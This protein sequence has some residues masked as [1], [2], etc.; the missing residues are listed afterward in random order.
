MAWPCHT[1]LALGLLTLTLTFDLGVTF[2]PDPWKVLQVYRVTIGGFSWKK[3]SHYRVCRWTYSIDLDLWPWFWPQWWPLTPTLGRATNLIKIHRAHI[4]QDST[5]YTSIISSPVAISNPILHCRA[6]LD[7]W[8]YQWP[9]T[10]T[11]GRSSKW[12]DLLTVKNGP[13]KQTIP[14][15]NHRLIIFLDCYTDNLILHCQVTFDLDLDPD[16]WFWPWIGP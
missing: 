8:P 9:L 7:L 4:K 13:T 16:L 1:S 5:N 14:A 3:P 11:H 10:L 6:D 2:D 15:M 12:I